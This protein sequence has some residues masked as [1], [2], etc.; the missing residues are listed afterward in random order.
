MIRKFIDK[1]KRKKEP[2]LKLITRSNPISMN[3]NVVTYK[4]TNV[5]VKTPGN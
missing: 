3:G 1:F 5:T 4:I 2:P